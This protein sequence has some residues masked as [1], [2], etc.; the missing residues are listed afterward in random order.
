MKWLELL[1]DWM[2]KKAGE[3]IAVSEDDGKPLVAAGIA[4][5][6]DDDPLAGVIARGVESAL[7]GFT[8]GLD[9]IITATLQQ[10][11]K[12][13]KM[14]RKGGAPSIFGSGGDGDHQ[15]RTF[16]DWL[17]CVGILGS[18]K[19]AP[20]HAA[21]AARLQKVY[22]S[23][24][25]EWD[26]DN[27]TKAALGESSGAAGGYTVPPDFYEQITTIAAENAILRK[28]GA[29]EHPMAS[30]TSQFPYLD[31]TT[32]QTAGNSPF[33]G[34]VIARWTAEAQNRTE[35]EPQFKMMELKA[36]ELSGYTVSSNVLLQDS[37][38]GLDKLLT[39]LFGLAVAWYEDFAFLQGNGVG[40]PT[41]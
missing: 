11:T 31:I 4:K 14:S 1:K 30:A 32:V 24:R 20:R 35:T 7:A 3:R 9:G 33:F 18:A 8:K 13:Q 29:Y 21:A 23:Q 5:W 2:G 16:G 28:Y 19:E 38:I 22:G 36:W 26:A 15:G 37:A 17:L 41:G 12:A 27:V 25:V 10:F 34:G 40:K 6:V 39:T